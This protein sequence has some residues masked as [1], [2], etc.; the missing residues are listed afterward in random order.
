MELSRRDYFAAAA[1]QAMITNEKLLSSM[2]DPEGVGLKD[3]VA[4]L[5]VAQADALIEELVKR[6]CKHD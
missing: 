3:T 1:M 6:G 2:P 5:A 4:R